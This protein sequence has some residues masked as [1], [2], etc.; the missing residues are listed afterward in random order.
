MNEEKQKI[1]ESQSEKSPE[2]INRSLDVISNPERKI[3]HV[4]EHE[5]SK[6]NAEKARADIERIDLEDAEKKTP[7]VSSQEQKDDNFRWTS[8]ELTTQT[9]ERTLSSVRNRLKK[10]E[11]RFSKVVHQPVIEKTSDLMEQTVVRPSG[12]LF[13]SIFSFVGSLAAYLLAKR[14]GGDMP[15]SVFGLFFVGGFVFGLIVEFIFKTIK[16]RQNR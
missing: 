10:P 9:Y 14:L 15:Y 4:E 12:V 13:G 1:H 6:N 5:Q 2:T 3:S 16:K 11:K 8:K 7:D